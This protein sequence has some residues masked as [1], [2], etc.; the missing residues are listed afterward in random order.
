MRPW[1][2]ELRLKRGFTHDAVAKKAGI[3]R[4]YYTMIENGNRTPSVNVAKSIGEV[5]GFDW[6]IFFDCSSNEMKQKLVP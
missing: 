4:S 1:L 3:K 2:K 5:I 6:T